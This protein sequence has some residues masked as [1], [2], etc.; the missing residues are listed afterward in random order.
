MKNRAIEAGAPRN[1]SSNNK[2]EPNRP[3]YLWDAKLKKAAAEVGKSIEKTEKED[4]GRIK[5]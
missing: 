1:D 4:N 2:P 5:G 3:A